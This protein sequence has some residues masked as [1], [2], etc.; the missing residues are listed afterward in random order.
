MAV[1]LSITFQGVFGWKR[2]CADR[3]VF[4]ILITIYCMAIM[5]IMKYLKTVMKMNV[6]TTRIL[7]MECFYNPNSGNVG[8]FL[9]FL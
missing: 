9:K 1:R 3:S 4:Y 5:E 6:F 7:E 2:C 8:T